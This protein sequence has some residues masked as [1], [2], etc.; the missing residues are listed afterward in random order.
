M[1]I[2]G[3]KGKAISANQQ[4]AQWQKPIRRGHP[5]RRLDRLIPRLVALHQKLLANSQTAELLLAQDLA[6]IARFAAKR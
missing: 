2:F 1:E 3:E 5:E 6:E 4:I